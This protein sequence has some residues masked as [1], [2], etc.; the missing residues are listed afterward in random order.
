MKTESL[1]K[2]LIGLEEINQSEREEICGGSVWFPDKNGPFSRPDIY[3]CINIPPVKT[4]E[5][6][7]GGTV[8]MAK[9]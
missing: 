3:C 4:I 2:S 1:K 6:I 8:L 5:D 7:L 9:M